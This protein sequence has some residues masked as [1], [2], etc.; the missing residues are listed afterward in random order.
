MTAPGMHRFIWNLHYPA[1]ATLERDYP[2]SAIYGDTPLY[3][4]GP[5]VLP[6]T[7]SVQLTVEGKTSTQPLTIKMDPRVKTSPDDLKA[8][9]DLAAKVTA[10]MQSDFQA[11]AQ[12][13]VLRKKLKDVQAVDGA[14]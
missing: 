13:R 7:Y 4:L 12:L 2:I 11:L 5:S 1:P 6:G 8:Q 9:F 14:A 10:A 3:P